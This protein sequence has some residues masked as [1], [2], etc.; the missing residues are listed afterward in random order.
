MIVFDAG[1]L[2]AYLDARDQFHERAT[3]FMEEYVEFEF[4]ANVLTVAES[5]IRPAAA[6]RSSS[7]VATLDR[8]GVERIGLEPGDAT[9]IA[10]IRA[11]SGLKMSDTVVLFTAERHAAELVTTDRS[12]ARAA[13]SHGV[14]VHSLLAART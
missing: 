3:G 5:L 12:L 10:E 14:A 7:V 9:A 4:A 11:S 2:I 1:V 6:G 8:L 13:E